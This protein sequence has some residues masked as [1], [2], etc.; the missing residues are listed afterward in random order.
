MQAIEKA[1]YVA[2]IDG[3]ADYFEDVK[4]SGYLSKPDFAQ[5]VAENAVRKAGMT[6]SRKCPNVVRVLVSE[7]ELVKGRV[8]RK[9][10]VAKQVVPPYE[11][12]REQELEEILT[13]EL[14][15]LPVEFHSF[16]REESWDRGHSY[17]LEE[18][19]NIA[20]SLIASLAPPVRK[21]TER[22]SK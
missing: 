6:T 3:F 1:S 22:I 16:V 2:V 11:P 15:V 9:P 17:G 5:Q 8:V 13:M 7:L 14:K 21:Y 10:V 4:V 20:K 18:V 19:A 12:L